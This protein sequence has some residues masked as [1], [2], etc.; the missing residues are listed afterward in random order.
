MTGSR[1]DTLLTE[2]MAD[3]HAALRL[4]DAAA[5]THPHLDDE[6][7]A[8]LAE[9]SPRESAIVHA[10]RCRACAARLDAVADI[11]AIH[12]IH[13]GD[14]PALAVDPPPALFASIARRPDGVLRVLATSGPRRTSA[15]LQVRRGGRASA[16][17]LVV[18]L[19]DAEVP[20]WEFALRP[21]GEANRVS[22]S[23]TWRDNTRTPDALR[24]TA[25]GRVLAETTFVGGRAAFER[26]RPGC[27]R[28][29]AL[30]RERALAVAWLRW[31]PAP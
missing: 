25:A 24:V 27:W 11:L 6:D 18:G 13:A 10:V 7:I 16:P 30:R 2:A 22:L 20:T 26:L 15:A 17:D 12:P 8:A 5:R 23:A 28:V 9:G 31:E 1:L 3:P 21:S 4:I 19:R 14:A 29:E